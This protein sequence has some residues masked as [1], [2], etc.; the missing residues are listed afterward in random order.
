MNKNLVF[1]CVL[2][3]SPLMAVQNYIWLINLLAIA[4]KPEQIYVHIVSELP[5]EYKAYLD[6]VGVHIVYKPTFDSR[7]KYC[8]KLVQLETFI[9]SDDYD[10]V[11][12][13]DCDTAVVDLSGI[14]LTD[15]VYAKVVDFPNPPLNILQNIFAKND[16]QVTQIE[17]TF[18]I[19]GKQLTDWNN[20]NG[21]LYIINREF[22]KILAPK[23]T[24]FAKASIEQEALFT[25]AYSK[26]ADQ[27]G[28]ALAMASLE[29]QV[30][31]LG[32]EWN[33]PTHIPNEFD[34]VP[35]IVHFHNEIN[36]HMQIK[37][38]N[39]VKAKAT[40]SLINSRIK[41]SLEKQLSNSLFWDY[42][43]K[44]CPALGS[45]V[46]SRGDV[47]EL[48]KTLIKRLMYGKATSRIVDVGCG[49]LE[50]MKDMPFENYTGLDISL[51]AVKIGKIKR[52]DWEFETVSITDDFIS[53]KDITMCFDVLI[54]QS[55]PNRF[56]E[57]VKGLVD[58]ANK[59]V[60]I[61]AYNEAPAYSSTITHFH[62]PIF[63]EVSE[64]NK[65]NELAIVKTYRDVSV[66]VG[67]IHENIHKRDILSLNLNKAF[68]EVERPDLLQYAVDVSRHHFGFFTTHYPRVFEYSWILE[69]LEGKTNL[70][71]LD[72]GAGVCPVPLC[73][74]DMGL[75]VTTVDLHPTIRNLKDKAQWNEWGYLDYS[76][77]NKSIVSKHL[78]FAKFRSYKKY[79]CIYSI[80]VIEHMPRSTRLKMLK[81]AS[82]LLKK[83][84]ELLLTIDIVPNTN[85]IWNYSEGK[86]VENQERHGTVESFKKELNTY[87]FKMV[88][89][90]IQRDIFDSRTDVWYVKS[91]LVKK[92]LYD[93]S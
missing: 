66:L 74:N 6:S 58:K 44:T 32:I 25:E 70:R 20:C 15:A 35:K 54:H 63:D 72:I 80:S 81:R 68:K 91:T 78:D 12:L 51:E 11:F 62:N 8:N 41:T 17:S 52:P 87:G 93:F 76:V 65:F 39:D 4:V 79:D 50:L 86:Q 19:Q 33:Y 53:N 36:E 48:K 84:G 1:S 37:P 2:D 59:R 49:D 21:G 3:Y 18:S 73:L 28:F 26:H 90:H 9:E 34:C 16:L 55:N 10:Y 38:K 14:D 7:N 57:I 67:T 64:Y 92:R 24:H 29:K 30:T 40:I 46:G 85:N 31:H 56:K 83:G 77:F 88:S 42:R 22:L 23:W 89:E 27:V 5:S 60:I 43:Y 13:M 82:M 75:Q 45:G 47:L 61:G 69:Q 71:V